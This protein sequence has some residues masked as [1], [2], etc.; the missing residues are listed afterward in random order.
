MPPG[1]WAIRP[2]ILIPL[3]AAWAT[4]TPGWAHHSHA[5][6]DLT[7]FLDEEGRRIRYTFDVDGQRID[8]RQVP[9]TDPQEG[10]VRIVVE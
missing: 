8:I 1:A 4:A 7:Q 10:T 6:Y 3:V 9:L 2:R 5:N